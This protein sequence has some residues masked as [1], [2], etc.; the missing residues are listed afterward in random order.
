MKQNLEIY[1]QLDWW[2]TK[3]SLKQMVPIKFNYFSNKIGKNT[4]IA[5]IGYASKK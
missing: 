2:N 4:K 5:Y 1:N 3:H